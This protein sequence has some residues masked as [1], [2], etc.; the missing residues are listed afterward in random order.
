LI[1]PCFGRWLFVAALVTSSFPTAVSLAQDTSASLTGTI[2][3]A[4]GAAIP[5]ASILVENPTT[6]Q[7]YT[8][9]TSS[10]G[11]Y[12]LANVPPGP[13]YKETVSHAGFQ[14]QVVSGL[15]L[16]VATTRTQNV[17]LSAGGGNETV[18]V[19]ASNQDVTLDTTDA[20]I[21]NVV[22]VESLNELPVQLRDSPA[23]L[24]YQQPGFT[25]DGSS[26]GARVDQNRI[27]LDGLDVT[28]QAFGSVNT[29]VAT[30]PVDSVEEF[31]GTTA[32][33]TANDGVGGGAQF[34]LV[35]KSGSNH[36][37]G[38]INEYHRDT[39]LEANEWFNNFDGVPRS[40]LIRNQFG[41]NV[42]GPIWKDKAFFFFDYDGRRD[43]LSGSATRTVPT[44]SFLNRN[45]ATASDVITYY[46]NIAA[47]TTN[48]ASASQVQGF[49]PA[50][51]GFNGPMA[52]VTGARYPTPNDFSGDAGDL[53]NTA[54][55]R[56]NTPTPFKENAYVG[57]LDYS[58]T[59]K[60]RVWGRLTYQRQS[61]TNIAEYTGDSPITSTN[62]SHAWVVGWDSTWGNNKTNS[63]IWGETVANL[64]A[65]VPTTPQGVNGYSFDGDPTGGTFLSPIYFG[66]GGANKEVFPLPMVRDDFTW[67]KGS[68]TL[69]IGGDFKYPTPHYSTYN[70]FNGPNLG[71]GGGVTGLTDADPTWKFR[72]DDLDRNQTSLT[73]YDSALTYGLGRFASDGTQWNYNAAS[74][75]VPSGTG[76]Q[77]QFRYYET[78]LYFADTWKITPKLTL[79]YGVRYQNFTV[80]YE[81]HGIESVQSESFWDFM[82]ARISQSAAGVG[83]TASLPGGTNAVPYIS[84]A[85]GGKANK[86]PDYYAPDKKDFAPRFAFAWTPYSNKKF[87]VNG[88]AGVVYDETIINALLQEQSSYSYLFDSSGTKNFGLSGSGGHS[89]AYQSLLQNPRFTSL[90]NPPMGPSAPTITKPDT[91]FVGP[92]D[93]NCGGAVGPCGLANGG[94]FNITVDRKLPTPYNLM[95]NLGVQQE[96]KGGFLLKVSWVNRLGRRLLGQADAEQLIEYPDKASGQLLSE[97][98]AN[99]TTWLR[100]NPNATTPPPSQP[101]FENVLN[102]NGTGISNTAFIANNM[103]PYPA[104]GDVADT[105]ELMSYFGLLPANVGMAAQYSENTFFTDGGFSDYNGLL[106][107]LHKNMS[108]GLQFD[109]NYTWSHSIDNVSQK[110]NS[111]AYGGYGFLCDVLRPRICRANSDFDLRSYVNGNVSYQLPFGKGR[112]FAANVPW[113]VNEAIGGW[114]VS[115]LPTWHTGEPYMAN[116]VAFLMSYS[117]EDPALLTGPIGDMKAHVTVQNGQVYAFK[118]HNK[119]YSDYTAPVGFQFGPRNN[120]RGPNF[121][122]LDMGVGKTFAIWPEKVNLKFRADA[123]NALNHPNFQNPSFTGNMALVA[124]PTEFGVIPGT[125]PAAGAD[126]AARVLQGS[127]RLEF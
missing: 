102:N 57:R 48:T 98:M 44:T 82:N 41:G 37:H 20:T 45:G 78:E 47:G 119:A 28:D 43:T 109:I 88:G 66:P 29:L 9:M 96:L 116:S 87:V 40:P 92:S 72:P 95:F 49:D 74:A 8:A 65:N 75:V 97:A 18:E 7:K 68:H 117:N 94:A 99:L 121:F 3:D 53:L 84:Y 123:F 89:A 11:S 56:F 34:A 33:L 86:G 125:V 6:G 30:A 63:L 126:Y 114:E 52:Q 110:A 108:H 90:A 2:T 17:V 127:L 23:A 1:K 19:S 115:A 16:S 100:Q 76:L 93:P 46:T 62:N 112:D 32:G 14:K 70:D 81:I 77:T 55:Y 80:P 73:V 36:F 79:T 31:R 111:F 51:L 5:G 58:I 67:Q 120:L 10:S 83:G 4:T 22:Q 101:W 54:G 27:S 35:T 24:F 25:M 118:D 64:G 38:N 71:L 85:L 15:Y 104:R 106:T 12:S 91:P 113:F 105:T 107:T 21:G 39:D 69:G 122:L 26:T 13:G 103:A 59:Q 61:Q 50:G 124:P 60:Q 42:G